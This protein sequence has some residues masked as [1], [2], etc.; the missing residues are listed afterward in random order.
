MSSKNLHSHD[1]I[2]KFLV[3]NLDSLFETLPLLIPD[4]R[5]KMVYLI[6][7]HLE[8]SVTAHQAIQSYTVSDNYFKKMIKSKGFPGELRLLLKTI[9]T[10]L[11]NSDAVLKEA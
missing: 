1:A 10:F 8:S 5:K 4:L 2:K 11:K 6:T 9:I 7:P 3:T